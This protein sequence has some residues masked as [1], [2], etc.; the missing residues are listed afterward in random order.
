[1][2]KLRSCV[3]VRSRKWS[4][5]KKGLV[6]EKAAQNS[7]LRS[8]TC[9]YYRDTISV[10]LAKPRG[11]NFAAFWRH[12]LIFHTILKCEIQK[13]KW[14]DLH[15]R[16]KK[17]RINA[18]NTNCSKNYKTIL[19]S[20]WTLDMWHWMHVF[21]YV[22]KILQCEQQQFEKC[23]GEKIPHRK[24]EHSLYSGQNL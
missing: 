19:V 14:L 22:H 6:T 2:K 10:T 1:M 16:W 11:Q 4:W 7:K 12:L 20:S 8:K 15:I 23:C 17:P 24:A 18:L 21:I 9:C 5:R 13:K 3:I